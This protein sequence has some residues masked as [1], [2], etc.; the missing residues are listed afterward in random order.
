[1]CCGGSHS[2]MVAHL[3]WFFQFTDRQLDSQLYGLPVHLLWFGRVPQSTAQL[4]RP[5]TYGRPTD[6]CRQRQP[7]LK[8]ILA[9]GHK[10]KTL[11]S[12]HIRVDLA[13]SISVYLSFIYSVS[14]RKF[15]Q[16]R[17]D[18]RTALTNAFV[19]T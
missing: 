6:H 4:C 17:C 7:K 8:F 19:K 16:S 18:G 14:F 11:P 10:I 2:P 5:W 3:A 12:Q 13:P 1:M 15:R 9:S